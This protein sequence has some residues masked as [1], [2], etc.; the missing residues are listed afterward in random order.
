MG[1]FDLDGRMI[2]FTP[3]TTNSAA[4]TRH[5]DRLGG[6]PL[7]LSPNAE[8]KSNLLVQGTP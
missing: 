3:H 2:A 8:L 1:L 7:C 6:K 4:V 5:V